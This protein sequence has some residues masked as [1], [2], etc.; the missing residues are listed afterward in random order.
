MKLKNGKFIE[1]RKAK[2]EDAAELLDYL[3]LVGGESDNLTFGANEFNMGGGSS[4]D[5]R[6]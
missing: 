4:S 3:N 1:I 2:K 6:K 5:L